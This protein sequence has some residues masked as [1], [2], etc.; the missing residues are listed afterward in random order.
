MTY[1]V[2]EATSMLSTTSRL[3]EGFHWGYA[4]GERM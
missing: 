1:A 2:E 4:T 3:P